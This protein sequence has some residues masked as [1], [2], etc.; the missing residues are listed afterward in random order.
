MTTHLTVSAVRDILNRCFYEEGIDEVAPPADAIETRP[1]ISTFV[2]DPVRVAAVREEVYALLMDLPVS[3]QLGDLF[4][5]MCM[6]RHLH[7]WG[8][9]VHMEEL[10]ALGVATGLVEVAP[11]E[12]WPA[13]G[14]V[15]LVSIRRDAKV[16]AFPRDWSIRPWASLVPDD[17]SPN[18]PHTV[19]TVDSVEALEPH[20]DGSSW[21][22]VKFGGGWL[23]YVSNPENKPLPSAGETF[24]GFGPG[25]MNCTI[26][27]GN[28]LYVVQ[29]TADAMAENTKRMEE[30]EAKMKAEQPALEASMAERTTGKFTISRQEEYAVWR[31]KNT[32]PYGSAI[33]RYAELWMTLMEEHI[34]VGTEAPDVSARLKELAGPKSHE[35]DV[36]GVSGFMHGAAANIISQFWVHGEAF[37]RC[38]DCGIMP[39]GL[40]HLG[41]DV[42]RCAKCGGQALSCDYCTEEGEEIDISHRERWTGEWPGV[43]ECR[44]LGFWCQDV[45]KDTGLPVK[46][47]DYHRALDAHNIKFH[48]P[49]E[50]GDEGAH[51]DLNRFAIHDMRRRAGQTTP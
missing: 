51:E 17:Q 24:F 28:R 10:L 11:R 47:D 49:C 2:F 45:Y 5:N 37:R 1:Y 25:N 21:F 23:C 41:C 38:P 32:D 4:T 31:E 42:E 43:I 39:G 12:S 9:H 50:A 8:E 33:F 20:E 40:H 35:A 29:S 22:H 14:G 27:V 7:Q 46:K 44:E 30:L 6:D 18:G 15:P 13:L 26:A 16:I 48:V 19:E 34:P 36:E 3:F